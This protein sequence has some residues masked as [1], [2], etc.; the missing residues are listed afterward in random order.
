MNKLLNEYHHLVEHDNFD[1]ST[2][3]QGKEFLWKCWY[4]RYGF[5]LLTLVLFAL[6][7]FYSLKSALV[8]AKSNKQ[9]VL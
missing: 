3:M 5:P 7:S 8:K 6:Y 4:R 2:H 9:R 1:C